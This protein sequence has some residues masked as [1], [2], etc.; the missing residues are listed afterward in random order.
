MDEIK[1]KVAF[2]THTFLLLRKFNNFIHEMKSHLFNILKNKF[3]LIRERELFKV[4]YRIAKTIVF[5]RLCFK[6][7]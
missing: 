2:K 3:P 5:K 7:Y 4:Y 6:Y 1:H